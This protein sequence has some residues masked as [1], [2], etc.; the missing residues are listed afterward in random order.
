MRHKARGIMDLT[1]GLVYILFS[2]VPYFAV[3]NHFFEVSMAIAIAFGALFFA[4][5]AFRVYRA[6]LILWKKQL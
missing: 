6:Y 5:G 1:M 2:I 3:K 4:Y